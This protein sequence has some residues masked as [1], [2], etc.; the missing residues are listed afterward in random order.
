MSSGRAHNVEV[1][2]LVVEDHISLANRIGEGLRDAGFAVDVGYAGAAALESTMSTDYDVVVL[3]RDLPAVHV[4]LALS[5]GEAGRP[6]KT[7]NNAHR[8]TVLNGCSA[9]FDHQCDCSD[10]DDMRTCARCID[11]LGYLPPTV[12]IGVVLALKDGCRS[13]AGVRRRGTRA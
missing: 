12:T 3:D 13:P 6:P 5:L 10:S 11:A 9:R 1:R 4:D 2:V 8:A 7:V